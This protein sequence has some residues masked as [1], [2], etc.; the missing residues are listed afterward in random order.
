[1]SA[2]A[3]PISSC[4]SQPVHR[5]VAADSPKQPLDLYRLYNVVQEEGGSRL[6]ISNKKWK[7][8]A[9]GMDLP[10]ST[11]AI[12]RK[13]FQR[14]LVK[15]EQAEVAEDGPDLLIPRQKENLFSEPVEARM[16]YETPSLDTGGSNCT[17]CD[18]NKPRN[19]IRP[20]F[21]KAPGKSKILKRLGPKNNRGRNFPHF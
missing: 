14:Y 4:P 1:M 9:Q 17:R 13:I 20:Y 21:F 12:L 6:C 5:K 18:G 2:R 10:V 16:G 19:H 8:I 11:A 7:R 15:F 3:T